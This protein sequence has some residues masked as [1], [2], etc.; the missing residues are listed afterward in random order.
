MLN[1][2]SRSRTPRSDLDLAIDR[3]QVAV[4]GARA[5][6]KVLG[7]LGIE[8]AQCH[9]TQHFDLADAQLVGIAH[10]L[11]GRS[12]RYWLGRCYPAW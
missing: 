2:V 7:N 5:N 9:E 11:L 8:P 6:D 1:N 4:D 10:S 3:G 12:E